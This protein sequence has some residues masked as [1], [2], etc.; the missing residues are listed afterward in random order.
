MPF[1][2]RLNPQAFALGVQVSM[3]ERQYPCQFPVQVGGIDH[4]KLLTLQQLKSRFMHTGLKFTHLAGRKLF[5]LFSLEKLFE[6]KKDEE[7]GVNF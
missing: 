7:G 2:P 6:A 4:F 3:L 5:T 1:R